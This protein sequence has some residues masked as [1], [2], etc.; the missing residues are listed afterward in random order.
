ME[1]S[2]SPYNTLVQAKKLN[3][4]F[5]YVVKLFPVFLI[6]AKDEVA[7]REHHAHPSSGVSDP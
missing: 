5:A 4:S 2:A 6:M 3:K 1:S 7:N